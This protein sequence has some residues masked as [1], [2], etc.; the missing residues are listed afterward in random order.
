[1]LISAH[2]TSF[3]LQLYTVNAPGASEFLG[4]LTG[5]SAATGSAGGAITL[6]LTESAI[7]AGLL[8]TCIVSAVLLYSGRNID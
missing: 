2:P 1:M 8:Q 5:R 7:R 6:E 4:Q 3:L